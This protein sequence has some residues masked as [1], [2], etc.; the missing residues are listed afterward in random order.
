[1]DLTSDTLLHFGFTANVWQEHT[2]ATPTCLNLS[3]CLNALLTRAQRSRVYT[4]LERD[5]LMYFSQQPNIT[6]YL[7]NELRAS[8]IIWISYTS[9]S[10]PREH[11]QIQAS[12]IPSGN[13]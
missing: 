6:I 5:D 13:C 3:M 1:M 7:P 4:F 12:N 9:S 8:E 11:A 2:W 10:K